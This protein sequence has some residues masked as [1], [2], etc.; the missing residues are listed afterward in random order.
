[1]AQPI[2]LSRNCNPHSLIMGLDMD[3]LVEIYFQINHLKQLF[4]RGWLRDGRVPMAQCESVADHVFGMLILAWFIIDKFSIKIDLLKVFKMIIVH[5][6]GEVYGGDITP[7]DN[8]SSEEK[9]LRE[10]NSIV[11]IFKDLPDGSD[12]VEIWEE[13]E[14]RK[15]I[16]SQF[17]FQIDKLEMAFQASVY[18][19][20]YQRDFTSF[21]DSA[22]KIL[23]DEKLRAIFKGLR[24]L[25]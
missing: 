2:G 14:S 19:V 24:T 8:I 23:E 17:V 6:F 1:M 11:R 10:K 15:S 12:Y 4:R 13:F 7:H 5:E 20:Q 3:L 9:Y 18:S 22:E 16:E 21:M 25:H